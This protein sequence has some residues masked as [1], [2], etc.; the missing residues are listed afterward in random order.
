MPEIAI[1]PTLEVRTARTLLRQHIDALKISD[2]EYSR[3]S[4]V[5]QYTISKFLNG[6]IK[7]ITPTVRKALNYADIGIIYDV[8]ELVERPEIRQA[9]SRAWDGTETGALFLALLIEAL[10]LVTRTPS[11]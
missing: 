7:S 11:S 3:R 10:A 8:S 9:L 5:P 4:G 1:N 2:S 6:H